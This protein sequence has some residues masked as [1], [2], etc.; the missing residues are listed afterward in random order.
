MKNMRSCARFVNKKRGNW[1]SWIGVSDGDAWWGYEAGNRPMRNPSTVLWG[2]R[3]FNLPPSSCIRR[4]EEV[5]RSVEPTNHQPTAAR[6]PKL[7]TNS[8]KKTPSC[9]KA[10]ITPRQSLC[11]VKKKKAQN[12]QESRL[13]VCLRPVSPPNDGRTTQHP[14]TTASSPPSSAPRVRFSSSP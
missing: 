13:E 4:R 12:A 9:E 6:T 7:T 8:P 3:G 1:G 11:Y 10:H 5:A 2:K 14:Q